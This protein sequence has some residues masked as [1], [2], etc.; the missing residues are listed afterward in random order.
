[1]RHARR[2]MEEGTPRT[3]ARHPSPTL[4]GRVAPRPACARRSGCRRRPSVPRP[5]GGRA[6]DVARLDDEL[7]GDQVPVL[8]G[9]RAECVEHLLPQ[10]TGPEGRIEAPPPYLGPPREP[11]ADQRVLAGGAEESA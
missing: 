3:A 10:R 1:A 9:A 8:L 7:P 11:L 6:G 5:L 2:A 4:S